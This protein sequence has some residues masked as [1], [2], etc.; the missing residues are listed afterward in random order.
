MGLD[1]LV[2]VAGADPAGG[3][4]AAIGELLVSGLVAAGHTDEEEVR[5]EAGDEFAEGLAAVKVIASRT[6]R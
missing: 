3:P 5:A 1:L 4:D 2:A 6:G